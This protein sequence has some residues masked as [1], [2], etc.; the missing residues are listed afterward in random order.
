MKTKRQDHAWIGAGMALILLLAGAPAWSEVLKGTV[1]DLGTPGMGI[2][3]VSLSV[4]DAD[5]TELAPG[6]TNAHGE[7]AVTYAPPRPGTRVQVSFEKA[8]FVPRRVEKWIVSTVS[9]L[10]PVYLLKTGGDEAY[11][12]GTASAL[13]HIARSD[14]ARDRLE[15]P[16]AI[17]AALPAKDKAMVLRHLNDAPAQQVV[18]AIR[19]AEHN[20][21]LTSRVKEAF[22]KHRAIDASK[23]QVETEKGVVMLSGFATPADKKAA[24]QVAKEVEGVK[25]VKSEVR[26][27]VRVK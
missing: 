27:E 9:A 10:E 17:I 13:Q 21:E 18:S 22:F 7:Y 14:A 6:L 24:V 1:R 15:S 23:V 16:A 12:R 5:D 3:G 25:A 11:Y 26:S 2:A 4:R 19:V 8:G 20:A